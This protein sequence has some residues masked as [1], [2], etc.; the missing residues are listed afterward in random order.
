MSR[1]RPPE[2][3]W[4][5]AVEDT[6]VQVTWSALGPGP[7][8]FRAGQRRIDAEPDDGPGALVIE[9][10]P[11]GR[12]LEL[13]VE[14]AGVSGRRWVRP[15]R[16]LDPPPGEELFRFATISD[17]HLG[18][19]R[20]GYFKTMRE[21]VAHD[22]PYPVRA[23]RAALRE[24]TDWG[25]RLLV[26]K[27]DVT[28]SSR[29]TQW[30][31]F[32]K[33]I[34]DLDIDLEAI[35]GNHDSGLYGRPRDANRHPG[36]PMVDGATA[37]AGMHLDASDRYLDLPGLRLVLADTTVPR[38]HLGTLDRVQHDIL[39]WA[40]SAPGPVA[41]VLHHQ[42]M[43]LPFPTFWPPGVPAPESTRFLRRLAGANPAALV[44]SGHTH[45]HRRRVV[46]GVV[47]TE[48]GAPK[49]FPGTW[50][51]YVV[52]EGGI[53][54]VVRRVAAPDVLRWT[55]RSARAALGLWGRWSPGRLGDRCFTH[56][57]PR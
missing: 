2:R 41:V 19:E 45:R 31:T 18:E 17:L 36:E 55:D 23:T 6:A 13:V 37:F 46:D 8:T 50:A 44:T 38:R 30:E 14:G 5:F 7:V 52:H 15:F 57:W 33:L 24:L 25:A 28:H 3:L 39:S 35:G 51:G 16:T 22:E 40:G 49:D 20:F 26:V 53:R 27:G 11:A 29:V 4:L 12:A 10:L 21:P 48:V 9:D 43:P 47:V 34:A 42:L 54:Q 1:T 56:R 32:A